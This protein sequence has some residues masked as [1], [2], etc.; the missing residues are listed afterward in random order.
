MK[1][2]KEMNL[3]TICFPAV[4]LASQAKGKKNTQM[5]FCQAKRFCW[6]TVWVLTTLS[7][8][9]NPK[10]NCNYRKLVLQF[11]LKLRDYDMLYA[12]TIIINQ[13]EHVQIPTE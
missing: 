3:H 2:A 9:W 10:H 11:G 4:G 7:I 1:D 6:P 5:L 12:D 8:S 13:N